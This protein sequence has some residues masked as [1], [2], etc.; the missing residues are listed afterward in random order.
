MSADRRSTGHVDE[1]SFDE[2][3]DKCQ[4]LRRVRVQGKVESKTSAKAR[5]VRFNRVVEF[6]AD[7][8][9]VGS[10]QDPAIRVRRLVWNRAKREWEWRG[11]M[12]TVQ[13]S[14]LDWVTW[15][16]NGDPNG[17]WVKVVEVS[18]TY[19]EYERELA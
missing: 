17:T 14:T 3:L 18:A 1:I 6:D 10:V 15:Q 2:F 5:L 7:T 12:L 9:R 19:G 13:W 4:D 16:I 8:R 11:E